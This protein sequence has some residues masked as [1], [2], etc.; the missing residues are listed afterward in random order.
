MSGH[1]YATIASYG[2]LYQDKSNARNYEKHRE[3][4]ST[5]KPGIDMSPPKVFPHL[6]QKLKK[7]Q[8][9]E[10]RCSRIERDNRTLVTRMHTIM[11]RSGIDDSKPMTKPPS[12][13]TVRRRMEMAR[14]TKENYALLK[15]IQER[16]PTYN[17]LEWEH[18]WE[19]NVAMSQRLSR[20][21]QRPTRSATAG[22]APRGEPPVGSAFP[23]GGAAAASSSR[24]EANTSLPAI[25]AA[26]PP[27]PASSARSSRSSPA[28]SP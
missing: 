21:P 18:D 10:E 14:I 16:P 28:N 5:M 20:L 23:A 19:R 1:T 15:R 12:Q 11:Q 2:M 8:L 7:A 13:G 4:V 22:A 6:Y 9:E 24:Q 3:R 27:S 26:A 25:R 17:H